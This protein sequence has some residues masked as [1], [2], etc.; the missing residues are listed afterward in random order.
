MSDALLFL[1][2]VPLLYTRD[3]ASEQLRESSSPLEVGGRLPASL[4]SCWWLSSQLSCCLQPSPCARLP[5]MTDRQSFATGPAQCTILRA[6]IMPAKSAMLRLTCLLARRLYSPF[7]ASNLQC[8]F[9]AGQL[10][11]GCCA[12][13]LRRGPGNKYLL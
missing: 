13:Y 9:S 10:R 2:S 1:T 6:K 5:D 3:G 4:V 12:R 7:M 11:H 8:Q